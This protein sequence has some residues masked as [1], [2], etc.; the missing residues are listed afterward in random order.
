MA[1]LDNRSG[2]WW[3]TVAQVIY[4]YLRSE[5]RVTPRSTR[6]SRAAN[7]GRPSFSA[8]LP[9]LNEIKDDG[10]RAFF[11]SRSGEEI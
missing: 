6:T 8:K 3:R 10:M 7:D 2:G 9:K 11:E 5:R 4:S 1:H